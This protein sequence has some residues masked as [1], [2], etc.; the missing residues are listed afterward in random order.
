MAACDWLNADDIRQGAAAHA[1]ASDARDAPVRETDENEDADIPV[2]VAAAGR[3]ADSDAG[4]DGVVPSAAAAGMNALAAVEDMT[5]VPY[6]GEA[7]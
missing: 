6:D 2:A 4:A 1:C 5:G 3:D 7:A